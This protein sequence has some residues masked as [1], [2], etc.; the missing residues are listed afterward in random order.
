MSR[1]VYQEITDRMIAALEKGTVPWRRNW[2]DASWPRN[3]VSNK[4]YRGVNVFLLATT[5]YASPYWLTFKQAKA[6]G[7]TVRKGEHG[8]MITFWKLLDRK[9]QDE[10]EG[11]DSHGN[12]RRVPLLRGYTVFNL[13]QT[14]GVNPPAGRIEETEERTV[15]PIPAAE[16]IADGY[17]NGPEVRHGGNQPHYRPATDVI[18]LPAPVEFT[19]DAAYYAALFHELGHSTGAKHRL[20]RFEP[21]SY[22]SH[23]YGR[24]ELVAEMCAAFLCGE[25]GVEQA[26]AGNQAAYLASW[27]R[28]LTEDPKA[29]VV[30]GGKAQRAA[31]LILARTQPDHNEEAA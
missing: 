4:A 1:D 11:G 16:A 20:D 26:T 13:E 31:D 8:T 9:D 21:G 7:G 24:E 12:G 17:P 3:L 30:A 27:V 5:D 10:G 23:A 18:V 28:V 2:T 29:I 14:D 22:G 19:D 15:D 6:L 25:A